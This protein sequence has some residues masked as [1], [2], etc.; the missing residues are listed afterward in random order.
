MPVEIAKQFR[1]ALIGAGAFGARRAAAVTSDPRSRIVTIADRAH[2]RAAALAKTHRTSATANWQEIVTRDDIDIVVVST[3]TAITPKIS[4]AALAFGKHVLVEK[5][6]GRTAQEILSSVEC[7]ID[8]HR[9]LKVG[10]N[11]RY[12][13]AIARA[14][15]ILTTGELGCVLYLRCTYGHGGRPGYEHE[16]RSHPETSGG[17]E[18]VDQGVHAIDLFRWF[19]GEFSDAAAFLTTAHWPI[20]PVED[21]AFAML[22][23]TEG[24]IAQLHASW[25]QW[26]NTFSFEITCEQGALIV[27]G[28]GRSY[29]PERLI[30]Q[31]RSS[32][33]GAPCETQFDFSGEDNSLSREW[34]DFLDAIESGREPMSSGADAVRTLQIVDAL[35]E[36]AR[37]EQF[38]RI[39]QFNDAT[40]ALQ[41]AGMRNP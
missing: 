36:S 37:E 24:V 34:S 1:V 19:A 2:D 16:W 18:L 25:T 39:V 21:N 9:I 28:L 30:K 31:T 32:T 23:S 15:E 35:Y 3:P 6:F 4:L 7:A 14:H 13:P 33:G 10:Y 11:H 41:A 20:A 5:P 26:K 29:G 22:R 40:A 17:G 8:K 38:V 27:T 12:H